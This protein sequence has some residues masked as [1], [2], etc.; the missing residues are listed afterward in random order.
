MVMTPLARM[1]TI[2]AATL[3][4]TK[5]LALVMART[6]G[7]I[8][9]PRATV[10]FFGWM[11]MRPALFAA[12]RRVDEDGAAQLAKS[13]LRSLSLGV[14]LFLIARQIAPPIVATAMA[15]LAFS[16]IVHFGFFDLLAALYRRHGVPVGKLFRAPLLS[17]SLSEF[18]S[19][20]WNVGF[21]ELIALTVHRPLRKYIG[22]NAALAASFLAS[23]LLHELAISVPVRAGY[24]LPTAYFALH[25]AL[26]AIERR[27]PHPPGR[28]WTMFWL[29]APSPLLFHPAFLRG[30]I[31]PMLG[32]R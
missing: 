2:I 31:D 23:G 12:K 8:L 10:E 27:M 25:G 26:V 5:T 13:G 7:T 21:S 29:V 9:G 24:G 22:A 6:E 1:V 32:W 30:V 16:L 15:M 20:R 28:I 19:R 4:V 18:W 14:V 11:G 17:R 3:V